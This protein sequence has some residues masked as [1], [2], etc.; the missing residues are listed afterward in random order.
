[1]TKFDRP[2]IGSIFED[3]TFFSFFA[4]KEDDFKSPLF[5]SDQLDM[6]NV[7]GIKIA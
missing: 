1:M 3:D 5:R 7:K 4:E 2:L 6:L